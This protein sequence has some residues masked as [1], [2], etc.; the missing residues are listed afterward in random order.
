MPE[1]EPVVYCVIPRELATELHEHLRNFY[2]DIPNVRV[3]VERRQHQRRD[4][5]E[6]RGTLCDVPGPRAPQG[7]SRCG[8][9]DRRAPGRGPVG[10]ATATPTVAPA[11]RDLIRFITRIEP[12]TLE[13]EDADTARLV[14]RFQAGET[15]LFA[16][17]YER[18]F[19]RV[20]AYLHIVLK[21]SHEVED[22]TQD[23]FMPGVAGAAG[24]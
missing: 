15:E 7:S 20:Y 2:R 19:D 23:V 16:R 11:H 8:T 3:I 24:L 9:P 1:R 21:E 17:L 12:A 10:R 5:G 6:A 18:Y 13:R 22:A 4:R 14:P